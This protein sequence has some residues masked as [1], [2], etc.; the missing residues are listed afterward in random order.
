MKRAGYQR[1]LE[2]VGDDLDHVGEKPAEG[3]GHLA[4]GGAARRTADVP[5]EE[6]DGPGHRFLD[7]L[8]VGTGEREDLVEGEAEVEQAEAQLQNAGV[9]LDVA[10][11]TVR[12]ADGLYQA[13]GLDGGEQR[14]RDAGTGGKLLPGEELLVLA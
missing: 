5:V 13:G 11:G 7:G 12:G 8:V 9:G 4:V 1:P 14:E 2:V 10:N 6:I 3:I